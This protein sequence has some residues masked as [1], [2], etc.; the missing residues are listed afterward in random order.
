MAQIIPREAAP[1]FG[2]PLDSL[3]SNAMKLLYKPFSIIAGAIGGKLGQSVFKAL[4]ARIDG[5]EPPKPTVERASFGKVMAAA[6]LEAAAVSG[7]KAATERASAHSF[8]YLTGFWPGDKEE[9][10]ED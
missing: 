2:Y 7:A 6:S 10:P 9:K 4:W 1:Q 5:G 8:H 3:S